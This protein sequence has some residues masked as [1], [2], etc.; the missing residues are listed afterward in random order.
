MQHR[1]EIGKGGG[2][3]LHGAG[4]GEG[5]A[6]H[7]GESGAATGGFWFRWRLGTKRIGTGSWSGKAQGCFCKMTFTSL[8]SGRRE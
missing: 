3:E 7:G 1:R 5:A 6:L 4:E 8:Y 2:G